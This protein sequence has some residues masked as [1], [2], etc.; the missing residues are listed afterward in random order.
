MNQSRALTNFVFSFLVFWLVSLIGLQFF[1]QLPNNLLIWPSSWTY[2][3]QSES[4]HLLCFFPLF[5]YL[6]LHIQFGDL[7]FR[8]DVGEFFKD[9]CPGLDDIDLCSSLSELCG[10]SLVPYRSLGAVLPVSD[11]FPFYNILPVWWYFL[12]KIFHMKGSRTRRNDASNFL[13]NFFPY[14]AG[15]KDT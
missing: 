15:P 12:Y 4:Y 3:T 11:T 10:F 14:E 1:L 2:Q 7:I 13:R 9:I 5:P 8:H 6:W